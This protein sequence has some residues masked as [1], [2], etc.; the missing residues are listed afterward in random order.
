MIICRDV[1]FTYRDAIAPA[2]KNLSLTIGDGEAVCIMGPNGSGKSTL[3]RMLAGLLN[4]ESGEVTVDGRSAADID[5]RPVVGILFQNPDNQMVATVVDQE[6]AFALEN[7]ATPMP[8]MERR[9]TES[10]AGYHIAHLASRLTSELSGGEKQRVALAAATI[11]RPAVLVLDEPDSFL[12]EAG[13]RILDH[14]LASMRKSSQNLIELRVTQYP[15]IAKS[16]PRLIVIDG[17]KVVADGPP[18]EIFSDRAFCLKIGL[19]YDADDGGASTLPHGL[20][21]RLN[22]DEARPRV[23]S[24]RG[25]S[26]GYSKKSDV[27]GGLDL[28][29][30]AGETIGLVGPTGSGKSSLGLLLSGVLKPHTGD[31]RY[32][33]GRGEELD[34]RHTAGWVST[35]LQQPERQFFLSTCAKEVAF[36]PKNLGRELTVEGVQAYLTL[37]GLDPGRFAERDPFSLSVGEKRRLAFACV[38]SMSPSFVIFD[39]PTASLDQ[40][41]V[42]RFVALS[43]LLKARGMGQVVISH[44]GQI[45]RALADRV[46]YLKGD[47]SHELAATGE[48]FARKEF[49]GVLAEAELS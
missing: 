42:G 6:V 43:R 31:V 4:P 33:D 17:G 8:E 19:M 35:V 29:I 22:G 46:L 38:L 1:T 30:S 14:E 41:G 28:D 39:E 27:I 26:F 3:A 45:I 48:L 13:R 18:S 36:G 20:P 40:E 7:L 44:E 10:L 37:V 47:G 49:T 32:L 24:L 11:H 34:S 12:D 15:H 25:V 5:E 16:Y 21:D 9:V 23:V 2:L